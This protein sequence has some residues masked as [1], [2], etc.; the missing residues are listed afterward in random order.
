MPSSPLGFSGPFATGSGSAPAPFGTDMETFPARERSALS[1]LFIGGLSGDFFRQHGRNFFVIEEF[2]DELAAAAGEGQ[3]P[4]DPAHDDRPERERQKQKG[5]KGGM[6]EEKT[7]VAARKVLRRGGKRRVEG[8]EHPDERARERADEDDLNAASKAAANVR[9]LF[10]A[11]YS[12][13]TPA[14]SKRSSPPF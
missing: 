2:R 9:S 8:D 10:H 4:N 5:H 11:L 12:N 1:V 3:E 7:I 6:I 13:T 14:K